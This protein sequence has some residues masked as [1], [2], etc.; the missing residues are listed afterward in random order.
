MTLYSTLNKK[1]ILFSFGNNP[2]ILGDNNEKIFLNRRKVSLRW[3]YTTF[4][5]GVTS[6][7]LMGGA[8]LTALDGHQKVAIPAKLSRQT[9]DLNSAH[10]NPNP[11]SMRKARLSTKNTKSKNPEKII[12]DVP[13]LIKS[14]D[15]DIIKKIP[16]AYARMTFTTPYQNLRDYPKFDPLKIFSGGRIESTSQML[17]DTINNI[18]TLYDTKSKLEI[19]T[20]KFN[21]PT[22]ITN[23]KKDIIEKD[24]TIKKAI[25]NQYFPLNYDKNQS[26]NLYYADDQPLYKEQYNSTINSTTVKVIEE[27]RTITTPQLSTNISP[28][29]ADDLIVIQHNTTVFKAMIQAGY[30]NS[31]S[32]KIVKALKDKIHVDKLTKDETIRIG[33]LQKEAESTII[34]FS[35]YHKKEHILTIALND[36]NEYVLGAEPAKIDIDSYTDNIRTSESFPSIYDGIW[37]ATSFNGMNKNLVQLVIR[38]LANNLNLQEHLKPTDFLETFFSVDPVKNQS[39]NDSELLYIHARFGETRTRFY[40]FQNPLDGSVEYFNENGKSSRPFLLRTPVPFGRITSGFGMRRHPILGYTRMHT[41]VDWAAPRGTP[42]IAVSD[43]IVEKSGWAGGYGKQT[44]I[45]HANGFVS[46][47]NHQDAISKNVTEKTTVKQGQI[48]GWIGATGLAT[49]P[50]LHYELI[51][52]GIKVNPM[53]IRIPEGETLK[54]EMLQRFLMETKRINSLINNGKNSQKTSLY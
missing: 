22:D 28:E 39:T 35:I 44:I 46:S 29:F 31:E 14:H 40:R 8:L 20:K 37:R 27:N 4:F 10:F 48:I 24:D 3:V 30:S 13:T 53:K 45:R 54:G 36:N 17:M 50:H 11:F 47:Y 51:V 25:I 2:P 38:I 18:D 33:M 23:I 16:F 9:L 32:S 15:K 52:N 42:I 7:V 1:E 21:F 12:I 5:A 26:Y 19:T 34:R 49:G 6:G 41:G 43:G